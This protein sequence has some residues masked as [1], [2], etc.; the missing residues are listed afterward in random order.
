MNQKKSLRKRELENLL[1]LLSHLSMTEMTTPVLDIQKL[2]E[3]VEKLPED[4]DESE[5]ME[6]TAVEL[7]EEESEKMKET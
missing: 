7:K 1:A 6:D 2:S 4:D 5:S 3:Q